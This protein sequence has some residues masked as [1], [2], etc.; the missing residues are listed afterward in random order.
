MDIYLAS[1]EYIC[2]M[3][4]NRHWKIN[5]SINAKFYELNTSPHIFMK[6]RNKLY[7]FQQGFM[8]DK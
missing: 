6:Q 2:F 3:V 5:I 1:Y 7:H 4:C 8:I